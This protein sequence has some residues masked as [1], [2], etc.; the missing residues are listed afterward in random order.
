MAPALEVKEL[1]KVIG[2]KIIVDRISFS[3]DEG[4]TFGFLGAN[5]SGKTTTFNMLS[6]LLKP[7][8]GE[9]TIFGRKVKDA[10]RDVG[11]VTQQ[12]S[13]YET[14]TVKENLEFFASQYGIGRAKQQEIVKKIISQI[15]LTSKA[16]ALASKLSGGMKKRLNMGCSL[17]HEPKIIFLDEPTVGLD[18]VVRKDIWKL[19]K[20]LQ[21]EKKTIIIT[22]HYMEEIEYLCSKVAIMFAGRIVASGTPEQLKKKYKLKQ[23]EDVFAHLVKP[24]R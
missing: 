14:L 6:G 13:F 20:E 9:A 19:I 5:G 1:A 4:E 17:V 23:M 12:D 11:F 15:K 8:S 7:S 21:S 10:R 2:E 3:V 24:A 18:P 22:S 16:N